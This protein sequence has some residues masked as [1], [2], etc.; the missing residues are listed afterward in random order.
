M[1]LGQLVRIVNGRLAGVFGGVAGAT[2]GTVVQWQFSTLSS[3]QAALLVGLLTVVFFLSLV[4]L[5]NLVGMLPT[6]TRGGEIVGED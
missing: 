2:A 4:V 3:E 6:D 5:T 1:Q